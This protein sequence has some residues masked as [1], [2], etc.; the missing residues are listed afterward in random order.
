MATLIEKLYYNF[1]IWLQ[2]ILVS[3]KGAQLRYRRGNDRII[4]EYIRFLLKSEKWSQEQ[5]YSYQTQEMRKLL[6]IAFQHVPYYR[7]MKNKIGCQLNDFKSPEDIRLLPILEKDFIR[8]NPKLLLN[9]GTPLMFYQTQESFS[10]RW[11]FVVRLRYWAGLINPH[12]PRRAQFTGR[13]IVPP[14]QDG[15][16]KCYWR[17]NVPGNA[18]LFS[19]S[20][21]SLETAPFYAQALCDYNPELID[22]FTSALF[23]L[24]RLARKLRL[25]LPRPRAIIVSA[26][27]L[28]PEHRQ[29]I[30][31]AFQTKVF[32]QYAASEPS[33]FWC[34]CEHGLMHVNPEYG[35]SEIVNSQNAP[36]KP[37]EIGDVLVTS[38]LNPAMILIRYRIGDLAVPSSQAS[39]NC[40]RQMPL[41]E[42]I[43]GR[44][45]DVIYVP[46]RGY[47]GRLG[48][49]FKG[50][51]NIIETQII[52][53][54]LDAIKVRIVPDD[55]FTSE[56]AEHLVQNMR[57]RIGQQVRITWETREF[58]P[59]MPNGKFA[60]IVS[61]VKH[62]YPAKM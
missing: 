38:F 45:D 58:I 34:E 3:I 42:G 50:L 1:P 19:T 44:I 41:I 21:I 60:S 27:T 20:H 31:A 37:G 47:V 4:K 49:V 15:Y 29:E 9:T 56:I 59:R 2:N 17:Q 54:S 10:R 33:C 22:G 16:K 5:Y 46:E 23:I 55:G 51:S 8:K 24:A 28:F 48:Q 13:N 12:Y 62:L 61:H 53:E 40:G 32:N 6:N 43:E 36:V 7:E 26:E 30:E 11:A 25:K 35:I 52:Q 14:N 39:C 18:M 57:A